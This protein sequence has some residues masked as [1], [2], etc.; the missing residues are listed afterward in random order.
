[1]L[2]YFTMVNFVS[3]KYLG[4]KKN[5]KE[6]FVDSI[7]DGFFSER[8]LHQIKYAKKERNED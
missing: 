3:K 2:E 8:S 5:F 6:E 7:E 4:S 1:M